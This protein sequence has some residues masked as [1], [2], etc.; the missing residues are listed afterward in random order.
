MSVRPVHELV[1]RTGESEAIFPQG[2]VVAAQTERIDDV[3]RGRKRDVSCD[4]SGHCLLPV[5][6]TERVT[7]LRLR[8]E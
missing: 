1:R 3:E 6:D 5:E 2:A 8:S 7:L 4:R